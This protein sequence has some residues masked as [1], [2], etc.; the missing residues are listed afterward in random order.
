M[1]NGLPAS[2]KE[3]KPAV[4]ALGLTIFALVVEVY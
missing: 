3:Y 1:H 2:A 4:Q